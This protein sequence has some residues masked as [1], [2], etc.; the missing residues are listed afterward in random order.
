MIRLTVNGLNLMRLTRSFSASDIRLYDV[1][2]RHKQ[3]TARLRKKD[4]SKAV[5][6]LIAMCYNYTV[7][8]D[9]KRYVK[10]FLTRL[11]LI[12]A[13][14]ILTALVFCTNFFVWRIEL[15]GAE[16]AARIAAMDAL[17]S[18]GV[19]VFAPKASIDGSAAEAALRAAGMTAASVS[20]DGNVVRVSVLTSDKATDPDESG[21]S[22]VSAYDGVVTRIIVESG[23]PCVKI[24]DVVKRG[25]TLVSGDIIS[26]SDGSVI[27]TTEVKG[28]VYAE[29]TFGYSYPIAPEGEDDEILAAAIEEYRKE[30]N[31]ELSALF[32]KEFDCRH[33]IENIGG[34]AV[35][36]IYFTAEI[37]IGEI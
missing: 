28:K 37:I 26:V 35:L 19:T 22:L 12:V 8:D 33:S 4:M 9:T 21:T 7:E 3:L 24:G 15:V 10:G 14:L 17:E 5:A 34:V 27:G 29:V 20:V 30:K 2:L 6:I 11:P 23:T 18:S 36:K 25:D 31:D 32:E 1:D 13:S 16:G